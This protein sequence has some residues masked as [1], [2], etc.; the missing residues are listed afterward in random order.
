M[1]LYVTRQTLEDDGFSIELA[2]YLPDEG[3]S[4]KI[5]TVNTI[6]EME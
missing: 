4:F 3:A 5:S 6:K 2:P 1:G